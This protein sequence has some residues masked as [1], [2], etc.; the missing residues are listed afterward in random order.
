M[1]CLCNEDTPRMR[2]MK[3]CLKTCSIGEV[4]NGIYFKKTQQYLSACSGIFTI[5]G[6]LFILG[7]SI[8]VFIQISKRDQ[9][10]TVND[11]IDSG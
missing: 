8:N 11:L 9:I 2:K 4:N 10:T 7:L 1:G 3:K 5:I 6:L